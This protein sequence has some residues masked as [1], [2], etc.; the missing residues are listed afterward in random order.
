MVAAQLPVHG[1]VRLEVRTGLLILDDFV[2]REHAREPGRALQAGRHVQETDVVRGRPVVTWNLRHV[3]VVPVGHV[4]AAADAEE[5]VRRRD[6]VHVGRHR[7]VRELR[8]LA[9]VG[10]RRIGGVR[11]RQQALQ[12]PPAV[13]EGHAAAQAVAHLPGQVGGDVL[14]L[15]LPRRAVRLARRVAR[16]RGVHRPLNR[17]EGRLVG[18]EEPCTI[19]LDRSAE[20]ETGLDAAHFVF[21]IG[22][23]LGEI[24]VQRVDAKR[25]DAGPEHVRE[26]LGRDGPA[27]ELVSLKVEQ[28]VP[29][30]GV[31]AALG[32]HVD[33]A[34]GG[35]A[36]LRAVAA[37]LDLDFLDEVGNHVLARDALL[38]VRGLDAV[39]DVA[40]LAGARAVDRQAAELGFRV[41]AGRL[42][43]ERR[44][45]AALREQIDL[46]A[47]D[48]RLP[49]ALLD[50]DER[51]LGRDLHRFGDA[52]QPER[53]IH[54]LDLAEADADVRLL[55]RCE[56]LQ[57][58]GDLVGARGDRREAID[59]LCVGGGAQD[60]AGARS[61][62]DRDAG[63]HCS[64]TVLD[65]AFD[66]PTLFLRRDRPG[67]QK[68]HHQ[69][70]K[71]TCS[72]C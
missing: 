48:V 23:V 62:F 10:A 25:R 58:R 9:V 54:L 71:C 5:Q 15:T 72:H 56:A 30:K 11:R 28:R 45:I 59:A 7:V 31:R 12:L 6:P 42:R 57:R 36:E 27:G 22:D 61:R 18:A 32:D 19:R 14:L 65:D 40:V 51:R 64:G 49:R 24:R 47:R 26:P 68:S 53:Q 2:V 38:E 4:V 39:D 33:D 29:V 20:R 21:R 52:G 66:G 41:G 69:C 43:D 46:L 17:R 8:R 35:A 67:K 1:A 16:G 3:R 55:L 50:V 60:G 70:G 63:Q 34:A 37:R 13:V 44:E